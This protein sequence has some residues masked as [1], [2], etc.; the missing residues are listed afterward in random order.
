MGMLPPP[1]RKAKPPAKSV[2]KM[3]RAVKR[4]EVPTNAAVAA[5]ALANAVKKKGKS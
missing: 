1:V 5:K 4:G 3:A 2:A